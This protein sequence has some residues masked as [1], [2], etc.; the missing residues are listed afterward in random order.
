MKSRSAVLCLLALAAGAP[1]LAP[2]AAR[3]QDD[4]SVK[5]NPF[6]RQ[7]VARYKRILAKNPGDKDALNKLRGLY[8]RY[9]S[10]A[11]L[12]SEYEKQ[13]AKN[14]RDFSTLV[15][16][17]HLALDEGQ[18]DK[19]LTYYQRAAQVRPTDDALQVSLGELY[20]TAG[21]LDDARTAYQQALAHASGKKD[22]L[23]DLR[24]LAEIAVDQT[25]FTTAAADYTKI[26]ELDAGDIQTRLDL[27]DV[28]G[29]AKR[30]DQAVASLRATEG[31]LH[32]D[33]ARRVEVVARIGQMLETAGKDDD[34][35]REYKRAMSL[36]RKGYYLRKELTERIIE[37]HRRHQDLPVLVAELE[38][39][40][41]PGARGHFEWDV[42]ARLYEETGR[43]DKALAAYRKAVAKSPW[44][45]ETQ[46]RLIALLENSGRADEAIK[47]YQAVIKV[48]PGEPRFQLELAERYW[49]R[50]QDKQAL[51]LLHRIESRF[52][53]DAGV[54]AALADLFTRWGKDDLAIKA[55][56]RLTQIEP[57]EPSHLVNLGDQWFQRGDKKKAMAVW[58]RIL[59]KK[60][61]AGYARLG[62]VYAEHDLLPQ[63]LEMYGRAL[64]L[65][66]KDAALYKGRANVFERQRRFSEAVADWEKA[67]SLMPDSKAARPMRREARRQVVTLLKHAGG[68]LLAVRMDGWARGFS[69]KKPDV[70]AGYFLAEAHLRLG[71]YKS[72]KAVLEKLL[73]LQ[74]DDL[75]AME[76]LVKVYRS[77]R[78]YDKA[79]ALL[80][81][82]VAASPGR[83]REYYNQIAEIK[84]IQHKDS[85]AIEYARKALEKSPNDPV[86][87]QQLAERFEDMQKYDAAIGAYE[88]AIQLDPRNFHAYFAL[89]RLY[90]NQNQLAKAASLYHEVLTR[91]SD[92]EVLHKAA[93]EAINLEELTGTLGQLERTVAPLAFSLAHKDVYRRILVE[94]YQRYVPTLLDQW[95]R[96]SPG[97]KAAAQKELERLGQHGLKPLLEAL[98]DDRDATQ[99][100]IAVEVLGYLGNKSAA[101][102]LVRLAREPTR[103]G[104]APPVP[105]G[106]RIGTLTPTID[107]P[108]RVEAL[109]AAG[110]LG[111]PR[112][113]PDLVGLAGH[114]EVALREAA[115]FALGMTGDRRALAPLLH[116]L[117]DRR[118]SVET[119]ACMGL[120]RLGDQKAAAAI[121]RVLKDT[122]RPEET[123][124][125][126]AFALGVLGDRSAVATL[127]AV[128]PEGDGRSRAAGRLVSGPAGRPAGP[129]RAA[130]GLLRQARRG[131]QRGDLGPVA[132]G[133]RSDRGARSGALSRLPDE[134]RQARRE[135][136]GGSPGAA[137]Q[138]AAA[139]PGADRRPRGRPG[140]GHPRRS[141]PAPRRGGAGARGPRRRP[142]PPGPGAAHRPPRS[143]QRVSP[144][145]G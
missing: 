65:K 2:R 7:V 9:R 121:G 141:R 51:A 16:L 93:R 101:P 109:V 44:E 62:Q 56:Q 26:L 15:V 31:K 118:D 13:L 6:D 20:R 24:A 84:T 138:R 40:W 55:Y 64:K 127:S 5:R 23:A 69:L 136:R 52:P 99:Q 135:D 3:A 134:E 35:I 61:A 143:G 95:R 145:P 113:I 115:T 105:L 67:L 43:E 124:A 54:Q 14:P 98:A 17:G 4:W 46:R 87:H 88:K 111:D 90:R 70:E 102:P 36:T 92:E 142:A 100:R 53:G 30:Y 37:I 45:L 59:G 83:E 116:A 50:G 29:K 25:D 39:Q 79:I 42:L 80:G 49:R 122:D 126:C 27:A 41:K 81:K 66:P 82:L 10:V 34:A 12:V 117:D 119:L 125:A 19:A 103:T 144:G 71:Q 97:E 77:E 107:M 60:D 28:L 78:D 108:L 47:Q 85:E 89:A 139:E 22:K 131:A 33:P 140:G 137:R 76:Q 110:R 86:A 128:L 133:R 8:K 68:R 96:G 38:K 48:A 74:P 73:S 32:A 104:S 75:D 130:V 132:G 11:L 58:H 120:A 129:A 63:A 21:K 57:D 72:A 123:R 94:I 112:T 114:P 18:R 106:S 91:A 1:A